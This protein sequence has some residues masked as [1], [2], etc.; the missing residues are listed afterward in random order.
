MFD[1]A[2]V[3]DTVDAIQ[4]AILHQSRSLQGRPARSVPATRHPLV[5][6][7]HGRGTNALQYA[8]FAQ[9]SRRAR[10]CRRRDRSLPRQQLRLDHRLS[11]QQAVA[12]SGRHLPDHHRPARR[13]R[14]RQAIDADRIGVA[15]HSQGGFTVAV[16]RGRRGEP[17]EVP[18]LPA[19][20]AEQP[21]G[22]GQY[23]ARSCRSMRRR[24]FTV[25]DSRVKAAFA[26]APGI[27]KAFGMDE[28]G[29]A[30]LKRPGLHHRRGARHADPARPTTRN[31]PRNTFPT[32]S[33]R[34][35][36]AMSITRSSSTN[37]TT[38]DATSFPRPASMRQASIAMRSIRAWAMPR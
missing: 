23:L 25:H 26:M 13:S 19:G 37:A 2:V 36:R 3:D 33:L 27:I 21:H 24:L 30:A 6:L 12:A 14:L 22:A 29:L 10:L 11:R 8:W 1:P 9:N 5:M 34:S 7:S 16:A 20:V 4:A 35:S 18:R 28:A 32:P 31:S 17:R 38:R 15:G